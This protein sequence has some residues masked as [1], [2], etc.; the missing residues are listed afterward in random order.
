MPIAETI[1]LAV[2]GSY[3]L[4]GFSL[5]FYIEHLRRKGVGREHLPHRLAFIGP[6]FLAW[7]FSGKHRS[8]GDRQ[9]TTLVLLMRAATALLPIGILA[10]F[11]RTG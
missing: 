6:S 10:A 8:I 5:L 1:A 2:L 7:T 9:L 4:G 3:F 11:A